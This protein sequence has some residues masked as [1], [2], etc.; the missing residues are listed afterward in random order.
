MS[1]DIEAIIQQ[2]RTKRARQRTMRLAITVALAVFGASVS[3]ARPEVAAPVMM[4]IS[5]IV[6]PSI[7][8]DYINREDNDCD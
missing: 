8:V 4:T 7:V 1:S 5:I 6:V 2:E 3:I